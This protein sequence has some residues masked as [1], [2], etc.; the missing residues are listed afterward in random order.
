MLFS[1]AS[2]CS[3]KLK[4]VTTGLLLLVLSASVHAGWQVEWIDRFEGGAVNWDNWTAQIQANYNNEVQCYTD[5]ETSADKNFDVSNGTLK[6]IARKQSISCPGLGGAQKSWTS[7]RINSKD[8]REFLYGR[9]EAKIKFHNLEGGSWPAFW[10]LE[11][12]IAEHPKKNDDDFSHWPQP[13]AGEID[14]WEWFSNEPNTYITNFFNTNGCASEVRYTYPNGSSDVLIWHKYAMEWDEN[15]VLFYIDDTLVTSQDISN[16]AQYKEPMFILLN[17][18]MGGNLGGSIDSSLQQVTM[19]VDYVAHCSPTAE[20]TAQY[21][22]ESL[23]GDNNE[24]PVTDNQTPVA[25]AI[26]PA[27]LIYGG[28]TVQLS[29]TNSSDA[30]GDNLLYYWTQ[31]AGPSVILSNEKS[32]TPTFKAPEVTETKT[33]TFDLE[34]SDGIAA[35]TVQLTIDINVLPETS[36]TNPEID[37]VDD[38]SSGGSLGGLALLMMLLRVSNQRMARNDE[39]AIR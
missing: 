24:T 23:P 28:D 36:N 32:A 16:C 9:I 27:E 1:P 11:N 21:C 35:N 8:K 39:I 26:A 5:D 7:G 18:A 19:E 15:S 31:T 22:D 29:A 14:V 38:N 25:V 33:L 3:A 30:D 4:T 17:V 6:I 2:V 37:S 10:M 34:V 12:R 20:N 13:G